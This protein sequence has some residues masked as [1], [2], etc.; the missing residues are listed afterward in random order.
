MLRKV[1]ILNHFEIHFCTLL[2]YQLGNTTFNCQSKTMLVTTDITRPLL[3]RSQIL[4]IR[5]EPV[6]SRICD[7]HTDTNK[8]MHASK[9]P[10]KHATYTK[11]IITAT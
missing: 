9:H 10:H 4:K 5:A 7:L 8:H 2:V 11:I 6:P 3:S 1:A